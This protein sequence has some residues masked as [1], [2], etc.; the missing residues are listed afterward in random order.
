MIFQRHTKVSKTLQ[1]AGS[2]VD[3]A[4]G[5]SIDMLASDINLR[6]GKIKSYN[7]KILIS[8]P[9]FKIGTIFKI[10]LDDDKHIEK[11]KPDVNYK[12]EEMIK[13]EPDIKSNKEQKQDIKM[14]KTNPD[15]NEISYDEEKVAL[16]LGIT[17]IFTV[18][19][20]FK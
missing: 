3:Y 4:I 5:E 8:S 1:Y 11:N 13:T 6:I 9:S 15:M 19:W 2:R 20:I 12:K 18:W 16:I 7:N 17:A 10:N 14:I